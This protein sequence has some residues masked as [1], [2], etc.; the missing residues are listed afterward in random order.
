MGHAKG[1]KDGR[2]KLIAEEQQRRVREAHEAMPITVDQLHTLLD[3]L[4][5]TIDANGHD[6]SFKW[7]RAWLADHRLPVDETIRFFEAQRLR[8]DFE[9]ALFQPNQVLGPVPDRV[10][11][12]LPRESLEL[13]L[14]HLSSELELQACDDRP[15]LARAW[16]EANRFSVPATLFALGTHGGFCDC[17]I[18]MNIDPAAIYP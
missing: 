17:E 18:V 7:T 9:V 4:A 6:G 16:L 13:L 12:L 5:Q 14:D 2:R 3:Q 10:A 8:D 1:N 11:R 15:S